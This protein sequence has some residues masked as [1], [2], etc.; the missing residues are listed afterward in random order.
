VCQ[1]SE[2][3][4]TMGSLSFAASASSILLMTRARLDRSVEGK[5]LGEEYVLVGKFS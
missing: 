2:Q 3:L 1:L 5:A 4:L